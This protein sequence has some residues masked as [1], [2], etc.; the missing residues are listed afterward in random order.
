[1]TTESFLDLRMFE[2]VELNLEFRFCFVRGSAASNL[3]DPLA[4]II[5]SFLV[6]SL[7]L[8]EVSRDWAFLKLPLLPV[9]A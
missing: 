3:L 2:I 4:V 9:E 6:D 7:A 8:G 5:F 1:M